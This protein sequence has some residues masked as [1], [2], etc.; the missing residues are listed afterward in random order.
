MNKRWQY[1]IGTEHIA[2][3][4]WHLCLDVSISDTFTS[5][6]A[7]MQMKFW[8]TVLHSYLNHT[9]L[10]AS[11]TLTIAT[12][13][14]HSLSQDISS[15]I[16]MGPSLDWD[17]IPVALSLGRWIFLQKQNEKRFSFWVFRTICILN[18]AKQNHKHPMVDS[19]RGSSLAR[20]IHCFGRVTPHCVDEWH[21]WWLSPCIT[22][23][24]TDGI[25]INSVAF[26][27]NTKNG[28]IKF[29]F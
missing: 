9:N 19:P 14:H 16:I 10:I 28:C 25:D 20:N 21:D 1:H 13:L 27:T 15:L 7:L 22:E 3:K 18:D 5:C 4:V 24:D 26:L 29:T 17:S 6:P 12:I 11:L 8:Q 2:A 23:L